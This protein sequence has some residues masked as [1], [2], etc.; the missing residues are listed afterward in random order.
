M[1]PEQL[2]PE[3]SVP[4]Q[5][6]EL[7]LLLAAKKD[8]LLQL[9]T[10]TA[11]AAREFTD[12]LITSTQRMMFEV[13]DLVV[14]F[15]VLPQDGDGFGKKIKIESAPASSL[16]DRLGPKESKFKQFTRSVSGGRL[17]LG[18][19]QE[20]LN[21][22]RIGLPILVEMPL[23]LQSGSR[24]KRASETGKFYTGKVPKK[25]KGLSREEKIVKG[26]KPWET[27]AFLEVAPVTPDSNYLYRLRIG[28]G[29]VD[30]GR[31]ETLRAIKSV[32][33]LTGN[34]VREAERTEAIDFS[35]EEIMV[36]DVAEK[37]IDW[38]NS[39]SDFR[40]RKQHVY[41]A[42]Q[43]AARLNSGVEDFWKTIHARRHFEVLM[44]Q[45]PEA[46]ALALE[47]FLAS[48][49][50][51]QAISSF[52]EFFAAV[53]RGEYKN[54]SE[55]VTA[56]REAVTNLP[57]GTGVSI[58]LGMGSI[59]HLLRLT[60]S[61]IINEKS[62]QKLFNRILGE[63]SGEIEESGENDTNPLLISADPLAVI[64][65]TPRFIT[66]I[67]A[68]TVQRYIP[69]IE[70]T[71]E[72]YLVATEEG[73]KTAKKG[74]EALRD[75]NVIIRRAFEKELPKIERQLKSA[76]AR[77]AGQMADKVVGILNVAADEAFGAKP[78]LKQSSQELLSPPTEE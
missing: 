47:V 59:Q 75:F 38:V 44:N 58:N 56:A 72:A 66:K 25:V 78:G 1:L 10:R 43:I 5:V 51:R 77:T 55:F 57:E 73:L 74:A 50:P 37:V 33:I 46:M 14:S 45:H 4:N 62:A 39:E 27:V 22:N 23:E 40:L 31:K 64:F 54:Y 28:L 18:E 21:R 36:D 69:L 65:M 68:F 71:I 53:G 30:I 11:Q 8:Q 42:L 26:H 13:D 35:L 34:S 3:G 61:T 19:D 48:N 29:Q 32:P 15:P 67:V 9:G 17:I 12:S 24:M 52:N 63:T 7:T 41:T 20:A 49:Q 16:E 60:A 2:K 6:N 76:G 70:E